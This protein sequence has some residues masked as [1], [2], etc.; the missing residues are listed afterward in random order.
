[1]R[2]TDLSRVEGAKRP[3]RYQRIADDIMASIANG[4]LTGGARLPSVRTLARQRRVSAVTAVAAL[5]QL[6]QRGVI[7]SRPQ[8]GFFVR[9]A[10]P[11]AALPATSR[12][13]R[14]AQAVSIS[15]LVAM[16][17]D[18]NARADVVSL[19][20]AI[21]AP[22]WFPTRTLQRHLATAVRQHPEAMHGYGP[23]MGLEALRQQVAR[24]YAGLGCVLDDRELLI[25]NGCMEALHLAIRAVA[26]PGDTIAVESPAYFGFLQIIEGAGMKALEI[27]TD[28]AL[29]LSVEGLAQALDGRGGQRIRA[30]VLVSNYSNPLGATLPVERKRLLLDLCRR[31]DIALIEDDLYGELNHIGTRPLPIKSFD[32]T[33][34]VILCS[35]FS[36]TLSPG[37]RIGWIAGGRW[38]DA[39]R[40]RKYV[41]SVATST[42]W[43]EALASFVA[44]GA[45][46]R[47]LR[48]IRAACAESVRRFSAVVESGFPEGTRV[49]RPEGG[50]ILWLQLPDGTDSLAM[51][52]RARSEGIHF[53]PGPLFSANEQYGNCLRLSC[54]HA[55]DARIEGALRRLGQL[56]GR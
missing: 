18:E 10:Q 34:Q 5:R 15:G 30:C 41:S 14:V 32:R 6:E 53:L 1:M 51:H 4:A 35:S 55:W 47:H 7:E 26:R 52:R 43:Q 3:P 20:A 54:G 48:R 31:H 42:L 23:V 13:P 21:P 50:Y 37:A 2:M 29:G 56:A 19:G 24:H 27:A 9:S 12:P 17:V 16:L 38:T 49:S 11:R 36:K 39:I 8:S 44:T 22:Q 46:S 25:T 33:G 40:Q 45:Y 28:P